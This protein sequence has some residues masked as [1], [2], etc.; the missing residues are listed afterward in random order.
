MATHATIAV[1]TEDGYLNIYCHDDGHPEYLFNLLDTYYSTEKRA[2]DLVNMGDAS[3]IRKLIMPPNGNR[4]SF[5]SP[6]KDTSVFYHRDRGENWFH[7]APR[8]CMKNQVLARQN[9]AYI[10]EDG[11]WHL[12]INGKEANNYADFD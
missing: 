11:R 9:Y 10:F 1:N 8:L 5:D 2:L 7:N 12:Y 3:F 6:A 4:H